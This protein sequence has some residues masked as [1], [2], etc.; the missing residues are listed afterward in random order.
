MT[1]KVIFWKLWAYLHSFKCGYCAKIYLGA[2]LTHCSFHSQAPTFL[3]GSNRGTYGCC[4][5]EALRFGA[6]VETKGCEARCHTFKS[7]GGGE[8][9]LD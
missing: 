4:K 1:L 8:E 7:S 6:S 3:Y 2:E 5:Q 9:E